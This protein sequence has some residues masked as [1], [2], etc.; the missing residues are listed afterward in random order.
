MPQ[1]SNMAAYFVITFSA[2]AFLFS[3]ISFFYF[4]SYLRR[5]TG[6]ERILSELREEVGNILKTIDET[7]DRDIS[8]IEE[9]EK[10]LKSLLEEVD[11]RL[12]VYIRELDKKR[13]D[14]AVHATLV[15]KPIAPTYLELG[16]SRH[17]L[18]GQAP[19]PA[20]EPMPAAAP[21]ETPQGSL[22]EASAAP[23][24]VGDRIRE[25]AR[26][27]FTPQIIASRLGLSIAEVEVATAF[28]EHRDTL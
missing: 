24:P 13:E 25:L 20:S 14:E 21:P 3:V 2:L 27:G 23:L 10:N 1:I 22:S 7:T 11:R 8:L 16:K 4:R 12:R 18:A 28:M 9:R 5:R 26:A 6:H 15:S 19:D 17:R